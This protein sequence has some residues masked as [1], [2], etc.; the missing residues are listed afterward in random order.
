MSEIQEKVE[1]VFNS[2]GLN[3]QGYNKPSLFYAYRKAYTVYATVENLYHIDQKHVNNA[4]IIKI[5]DAAG[6]KILDI[7]IKER[8]SIKL[9]KEVEVSFLQQVISSF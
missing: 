6:D 7:L 1:K 9:H 5:M 2:L 8:S 3:W 4:V